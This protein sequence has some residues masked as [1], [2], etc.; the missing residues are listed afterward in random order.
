[1]ESLY[2]LQE[3]AEALD[4]PA[5]VIEHWLSQ[6]LPT[7]PPE[8]NDAKF[9]CVLTICWQAGH[10]F[11]CLPHMQKVTLSAGQKI[12]YGW[13]TGPAPRN[14]GRRRQDVAAFVIRMVRI[15]VPPRTSLECLHMAMALALHDDFED[16][17]DVHIVRRA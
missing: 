9:D 17:A 6:G 4:K 11:A 15:G 8:A 3:L 13:M 10:H 16:V 7:A 1:M 5:S 14:L 2:T 12:A